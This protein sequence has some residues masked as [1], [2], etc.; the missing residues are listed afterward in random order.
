MWCLEGLRA[1]DAGHYLAGKN[2]DAAYRPTVDQAGSDSEAAYRRAIGHLTRAVASSPRA[3]RP[4]HC[5]LAHAIGHGGA[6]AGTATAIAESLMNL[7]SR[8]D[9]A[10]HFAEFALEGGGVDR[11]GEPSGA[12]SRPDPC[13][14]GARGRSKWEEIIAESR[15]FGSPR[16]TARPY[17]A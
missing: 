3:R 10:W 6:D 9:T 1:I 17:F 8:S 15:V 12:A 7:W 13:Y 4:Y 5:Q 16:N 14:A 11:G 2:R